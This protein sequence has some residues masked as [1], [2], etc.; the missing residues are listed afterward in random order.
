MKKLADILEHQ[1]VSRDKSRS[2]ERQRE[3][4]EPMIGFVQ[5][6]AWHH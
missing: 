5:P 6:P 3:S 2:N 1:R 4:D